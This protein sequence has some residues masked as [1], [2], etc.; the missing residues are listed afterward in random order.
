MLFQYSTGMLSIL[1]RKKHGT[2][3]KVFIS[4]FESSDFYFLSLSLERCFSLKFLNTRPSR[5]RKGKKKSRH[6]SYLYICWGF[7][8]FFR[9]KQLFVLLPNCPVM[10]FQL[11]LKRARC[12]RLLRAPPVV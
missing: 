3:G 8:F 6:W 11:T 4:V 9:Q 5:K 1:G 2:Q 7:T 10:C 12:P